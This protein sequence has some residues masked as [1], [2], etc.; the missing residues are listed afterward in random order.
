MESADH[1][2]S[3]DL[4]EKREA[5]RLLDAQRLQEIYA[6]DTTSASSSFL[7]PSVNERTGMFNSVASGSSFIQSVL[8]DDFSAGLDP[9]KP[10]DPAQEHENLRHQVEQMLLQAEQDDEFGTGTGDDDLT[11]TNI[12]EHIRQLGQCHHLI[13]R[14]MPAYSTLY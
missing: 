3:T 12:E 9:I 10:L 5:K 7:D 4:V 8:P 14:L 11:S 2:N 13:K 6:M 1:L